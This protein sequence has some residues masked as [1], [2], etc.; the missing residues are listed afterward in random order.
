[1]DF[2]FKK[3]K[4]GLND[5][6]NDFNMVMSKTLS[7]L[8][9]IE[10]SSKKINEILIPNEEKMNNLK[11]EIYEKQ[12]ILNRMK[13]KRQEEEEKLA[14]KL[15]EKKSEIFEEE[16]KEKETVSKTHE[17]NN[18]FVIKDVSEK[19]NT[20]PAVSAS[21]LESLIEK[22]IEKKFKNFINNFT[23]GKQEVD[24]LFK[25]E[26]RFKDPK[27]EVKLKHN[28]AKGFKKNDSES[29]DD[30]IKSDEELGFKHKNEIMKKM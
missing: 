24:D 16:E 2:W 21:Q 28:K 29:I 13:K 18:D 23:N 10:D 20:E 12:E 1:M 17:Q 26:N 7:I 25:A 14:R 9:V 8:D 19:K 15:S 5:F 27:Y 22:L 6:A 3:I 11:K 30:A 4:E